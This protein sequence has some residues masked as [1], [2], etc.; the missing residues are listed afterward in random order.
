MLN[1]K[2]NRPQALSKP[3]TKIPMHVFKIFDVAKRLINLDNAE[4][5]NANINKT[6]QEKA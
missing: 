1:P 3:R 2:P 5:Q 4:K 6:K